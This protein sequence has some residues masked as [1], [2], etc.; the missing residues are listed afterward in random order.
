MQRALKDD[1]ER[2]AELAERV[3]K[4]L[5][6]QINNL[7]DI[8]TAF[9]SFAKMPKG[10]QTL[11]GPN[12]VRVSGGE[13][14]RLCIARALLSKPEVLVLDE[15]TSHLDVLTEKKVH[16]ELHNLSE[17]QTVIAITHRISSMYLF[18]RIIVLDH[19]K[20]VGE[21]THANL[22]KSNKYYQKL[23]RQSKKV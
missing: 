9:S 10:V 3:S 19:G 14:Q 17:K 13:K 18:D 4:T 5:I 11:V 15:A 7:S 21:G 23:W 8:A 1:K 20:I 16:D 12:G 2:G 22:L 6:E